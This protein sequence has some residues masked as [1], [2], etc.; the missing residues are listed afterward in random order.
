MTALETF[1]RRTLGMAKEPVHQI[2]FEAIA[3]LGRPGIK[4][5]LRE[6]TKFDRSERT[7]LELYRNPAPWPFAGWF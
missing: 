1:W 4:H 5:F 7:C 6:I 2:F 3:L